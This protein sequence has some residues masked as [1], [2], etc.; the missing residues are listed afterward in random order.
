MGGD[1]TDPGRPRGHPERFGGGDRGDPL[2][3]ALFQSMSEGFA[4]CEA[5]GD[6]R[7]PLADYRILEIN[8]ALRAMLGVGPEARGRA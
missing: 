6:E 8:P 7:R 1:S 3:E 4:L 2:Y 5:L